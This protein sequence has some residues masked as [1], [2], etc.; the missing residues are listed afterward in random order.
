MIIITGGAGFI[1]SVLS[2]HVSRQG[3]K[4]LFVV[5]KL[6]KPCKKKNMSGMSIKEFIDRD[7]FLERLESGSFGKVD[8]VIHMGA[9][10][11]TTE[12]NMDYLL[13]QN[14][15][16]SKRLCSWCLNNGTRF[17]YAS[18]AS[19]YG[20]GK[21]SFSDGDELTS[22]LKP[23][24]KYGLSKLMFDQWLIENNYVNSVAGLRFFNVFGPNEYH[25]GNMSSII[26]RSFPAAK[27]D[28]VVRLFKSYMKGIKDGD[29]RRDFIYVKD[30]VKVVDLFMQNKNINGIFNVGTGKARSFN[31]LGAALLTSLNKK[32]RIEYFD[33]PDEIKPNYQY[34]TEADMTKL[35]SVGYKH[36]F[37]SLENAITDYVQNYLIKP[38]QYY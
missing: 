12:A 33:M 38:N 6:N 35:R 26:Y 23:L 18:S 30:V 36:E 19:V 8:V 14:Y 13:K 16:Y 7:V 31:E 29:Q 2:Q 17:I 11:D 37:T 32:V 25:K 20:D 22:R 4:D 21:N 34:F 28:S 9:C 27:K 10:T 3:V 24:N 5:D 15:E 1:G